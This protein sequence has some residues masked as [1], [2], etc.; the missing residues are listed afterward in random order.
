MEWG[1]RTHFALLGGLILA[2]FAADLHARPAGNGAIAVPSDFDL[3][4]HGAKEHSGTRFRLA[5]DDD[6][7]RFTRG[8]S[9]PYWSYSPISGGPKLEAGALGAGRKGAPKLAHVGVDWNF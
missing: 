9:G 4:D 5:S 2:G 6:G 8:P 7:P 1:I 3:S